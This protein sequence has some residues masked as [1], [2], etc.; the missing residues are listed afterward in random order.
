MSTRANAILAVLLILAQVGAET[1]DPPRRVKFQ[2]AD[3]VRI[4]GA[5]TAWD[6]EGFDGSF[7]R[8]RW[9][10][11]MP[12]D[13]WQLHQKL[14]EYPAPEQ[15]VAVGRVFLMMPEESRRA[16][17][18]AE[19]AFRLALREAPNQAQA[20]ERVR[21]DAAEAQRA[22]KE[23]ETQRAAR[24][25]N[26]QSPEA[27]DWPA[28]L[29]PQLDDAQ[30]NAAMLTMRTD[31]AKKLDQLGLSFV[32]V[33]TDHFIVFSDTPRSETAKWAVMLE[34]VHE[35]LR[36]VLDV[37]ATTQ[38]QW[39]RV[40]VFILSDRT[41]FQKMEEDVFNQLL[42][43]AVPG[44]AHYTGSQVFISMHRDVDDDEFAVAL[45]HEA[46]HGLMHFHRT[47]RRLPP[48]ANE[49]LA[50]FIADKELPDSL[51]LHERRKAALQYIR[52]GDD[53]NAI[54][55]LP[56]DKLTTSRVRDVHLGLGLLMT[57]LMIRERPARYVH[58]VTAI[59]TGREWTEALHDDYG[60]SRA[61]LIE[62]LTRY[63]KVND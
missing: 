5:M 13:V 28:D 38:M 41:Q 20:I 51:V 56:Y 42:P 7:G 60:A 29:W 35:H 21:Q 37:P 31:A 46:V 43:L 25:L 19:R 11:L 2:L 55:D 57:E 27:K 14:L 47:P 40:A 16:N 3:G 8:R 58:W 24:Q 10:D 50:Q 52:T 48:W 44:A 54:I 53:V 59:K 22:R 63:Y 34:R 45:I 32:P 23:A 61:A 33:E 26:T 17:E 6:E 9:I 15:W 36:T 39:G 49:G 30:L 1:L 4:E 12:D 62:V 18:L